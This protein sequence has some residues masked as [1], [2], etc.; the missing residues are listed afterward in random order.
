MELYIIRHGRTNW[1][2][3]KRLQGNSDIPLMAE[4][5]E[6]AAMT[7]VGL[8]EVDF[9]AIYA[10]PL[11][12]AYETARIIAG[13]RNMEIQTD[14]RLKEISFGVLE[15]E[16]IDYLTDETFSKEQGMFFT[17]PQRYVPPE[18]GES[19]EA[20]CDRTA[21]F[22][23]DIKAR[24]GARERLLIVAHGAVNKALLK[25]IMGLGIKDFWSGAVQKNCGITIIDIDGPNYKLIAS[26]KIFYT[27]EKGL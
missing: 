4:G 26:G 21:D 20:L 14:L 3:I 13:D 16:T 24:H 5:R 8:K 23:A 2:K 7:A 22:L 9:D 15:G 18:G 19:L 10:S 17:Q 1:N 6:M 27:M 11:Q 25:D 12:R